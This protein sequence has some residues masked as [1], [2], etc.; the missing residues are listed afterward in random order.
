MDGFRKW[1]V[2][3]RRTIRLKIPAVSFE[4]LSPFFLNS[5]TVFPTVLNLPL[6][7]L[8][9]F[10]HCRHAELTITIPLPLPFFKNQEKGVLAEGVSVE[11]SVTDKETKST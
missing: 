2:A 8:E 9:L 6:H 3:R 7:V 11:S 4:I 1:L 10:Y 5:P